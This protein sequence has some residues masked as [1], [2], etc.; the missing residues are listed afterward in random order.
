MLLK[1]LVGQDGKIREAAAF[2]LEEFMQN[3][4]YAK[5]LCK[6]VYRDIYLNAVIDINGNICRNVIK[7]LSYYKNNNEFFTPFCKK[8]AENIFELIKETEKFNI[9][10]GKYKINKQIFKLYWLLEAVYE[11]YEYFD[12]NTLKS[13]LLKTKDIH[14]YTIREKTAKILSINFSDNE[15]RCIQQELKNDKNYYVRRF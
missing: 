15:L 3:H 12:I 13:I 14:E 9:Q 5:L 11:F 7:A 10:D 8:I 1:H 2:R 6:P 4:D